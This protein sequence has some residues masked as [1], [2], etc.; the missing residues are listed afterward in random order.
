MTH[1]QQKSS[2]FTRQAR[3]FG[4]EKIE[5]LGRRLKREIFFKVELPFSEALPDGGS[6]FEPSMMG[7]VK[8]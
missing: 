3:M 1:T 7:I 5:Q 4:E 8:T 6:A 2:T